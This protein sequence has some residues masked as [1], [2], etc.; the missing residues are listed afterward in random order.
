MFFFP[1]LG[2]GWVVIEM[3]ITGQA[4]YLAFQMVW[5]GHLAEKEPFFLGG[6]LD[7]QVAEIQ[8]GRQKSPDV[9]RDVL[10]SGKVKFAD[11]AVEKSLLLDIDDPFGR[12]DPDVVAVVDPNQEKIEPTDHQENVLD[13]KEE[14]AER[15][16]GKDGKHHQGRNRSADQ[17]DERQ[18]QEQQLLENVEPVTVDDP[19]YFFLVVMGSEVETH[20]AI[21]L[22]LSFEFRIK[23]E[24]FILRHW[25]SIIQN[26]VQIGND[27]SM[28]SNGIIRNRMMFVKNNA[29]K[30]AVK[31]SKVS[32]GWVC[33]KE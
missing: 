13:E 10:Q 23:I 32:A 6:G 18:T 8:D 1:R 33:P 17:E 28:S 25:K 11:L 16:V 26:S 29:A 20:M 12:D 24:K 4:H 27:D 7:M 2:K 14:G 5:I 3:V 21:F 19:D 15:F 31:T 30:T 9:G 22:S